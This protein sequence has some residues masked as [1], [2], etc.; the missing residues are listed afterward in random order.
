ME[1]RRYKADAQKALVR[2]YEDWGMPEKA[3]ESQFK[4][5]QLTIGAFTSPQNIATTH[6]Q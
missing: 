6:I 2:L 5:Q 1:D 3:A 4:G